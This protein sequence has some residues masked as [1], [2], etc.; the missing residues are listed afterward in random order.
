MDGNIVDIVSTVMQ[1]LRVIN[2]VYTGLFLIPFLVL[3]DTFS[4]PPT[5]FFILKMD[6][7][8]DCHLTA[9]STCRKFKSWPRWS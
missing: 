2:R 7:F 3:N 8:E 5:V 1:L 4:P 6:S 9:C